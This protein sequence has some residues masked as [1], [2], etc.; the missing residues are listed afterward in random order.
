MSPVLFARLMVVGLL[1]S[2]SIEILNILLLSLP[3]GWLILPT[4]LS[5]QSNVI[6]NGPFLP[7]QSKVSLSQHLVLY[8]SEY[9]FLI[10]MI[11]F[12]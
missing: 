5:I 2:P 10:K 1:V 9:L 12:I 3:H 6:L 7:T 11:F 4:H 8:F